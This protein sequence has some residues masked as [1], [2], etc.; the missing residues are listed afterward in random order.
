MWLLTHTGDLFDHKPLWLRP[1][2]GH[3]LGRT[4]G[5]SPGGEVVRYI[6]HK[7]VSRKHCTIHVSPVKP[8]DSAHI[9]TRSEIT[10]TDGSKVG[11]FVNG[12]AVLKGSKV[13]DKSAAN[14]SIR[15]GREY[16]ESFVL[17]WRAVVFTCG[18]LTKS[19]KTKKDPLEEYRA[20][21][22]DCDVK[23]VTECVANQTSHVVATKRNFTQGLQA[24]LQ[25]KWVIGYAFLEKLGEVSQRRGKDANGEDVVSLLEEDYEQY[26][27]KV[28]QFITP[29][30]SEP[31]PR[32]E[33][34]MK[35][36]PKR[37]DMLAHFTFVFLS[38]AQYD[39]LMPVVTTGG[40]KA[41]LWEVDTGVSEVEE[42]LQYV[43]KLAGVKERRR[44]RLTQTSGEGGVVVVR[45]QHRDDDWSVRFLQAMETE[46]GQ[47]SAEQN[48]FLDAIL[49][50]TPSDLCKPLPQLSQQT[51]G[52]QT[53][54]ETAASRTTAPSRRALDDREE[55]PGPTTQQQ[56]TPTETP[57]FATSKMP[58]TTRKKTRHIVTTS[59]FKGFDDPDP[60]QFIRPASDSP[61]PS[62]APSIQDVSMDEPSQTLRNTQP[63]SRK[64]PAPPEPTAEE[65]EQAMMESLLP[66][67]AAM[68]RRK[69]AAAA[70]STSARA[71]P[72]PE[73][74][75]TTVRK[76]KKE[77]ELDVRAA[78]EARRKAEDE[79]RAADE[80]VLKQQLA[81]MDISAISARVETFPV[82]ARKPPPSRRNA[83]EGPSE[84][85]D[86]AWNGRKNFK[87]FRRRG[88]T[89]PRLQK[90]MVSLV[91]CE[92][93]GNGLGV[94]YWVD[95]A[96]PSTSSTLRKSQASQSQHTGPSQ[97][98]Q[99][100]IPSSEDTDPSRFRRR[101]Q[102]SRQQDEELQSLH[103][104]G[105]VMGMGGTPSQTLGTESQ[106]NGRKRIAEGSAGGVAKKARMVQS[107]LGAAV[108][109]DEDE[110]DGL[111]FRRRKRG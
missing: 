32:P 109:V 98:R 56:P 69:T 71:T 23:L 7:S 60:S 4:S 33:T 68:K 31:V 67:A 89:A 54:N 11:T 81:G 88:E 48:E 35:P 91:E 14:F 5:R 20:A 64:R 63:N 12:E 76:A 59:R 97:S 85:W 79:A 70:G 9:H 73:A 74:P 82:P 102:A 21:L 65:E 24:L 87:G 86:P 39:N 25:G 37:V 36:D 46:L 41:M 47:R 17:E 107:R 49:T 55:D 27:P 2:T 40:G 6:N 83:T 1:G 38:Q 111:K 94:E 3:L 15:L 8:G 104:V 50:V 84:R 61:E 93:R 72:A 100:I 28:E 52:S 44:P 75:A 105:A 18:N 42:L 57:Q 34:M 22:E 19:Q 13:L 53:R 66:G 16:G 110:D 101:V 43:V 10:I 51:D 90:V 77:K 45:L 95:T 99:S 26:W 80:E 78:L 92:R 29:P 108:D 58:E 96:A 106:R 62:P 30:G 103:D